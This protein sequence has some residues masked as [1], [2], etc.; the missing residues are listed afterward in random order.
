[1]AQAR[2]AIAAGTFGS[3][4]DSFIARYKANDIL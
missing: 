4:K 3:F 2:E 1:M